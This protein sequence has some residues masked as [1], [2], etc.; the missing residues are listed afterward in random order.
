ME[1]EGTALVIAK[2]LGIYGEPASGGYL[3]HVW[4]SKTIDR[5]TAQRIA[6]AAKTILN[7]GWIS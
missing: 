5:E 3:A 7:A 4:D 2:L 6:D 1:A